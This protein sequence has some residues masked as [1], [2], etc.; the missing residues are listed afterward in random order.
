MLLMLLM[1]KSESDRYI[2]GYAI[3]NT[4]LKPSYYLPIYPIFKVTVINPKPQPTCTA[5]NL[6]I[7][8]KFY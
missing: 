4:S 7:N 6:R 8:G 2:F 3:V 1:R 5:A